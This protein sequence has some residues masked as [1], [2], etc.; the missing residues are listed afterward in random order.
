MALNINL[1]WYSMAAPHVA[2]VAALYL[3]AHPSA[4][5]SEVKQV[6]IDG[7]TEGKLDSGGL[8]KGTPNKI[9]YSLLNAMAPGSPGI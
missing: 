6:I 1:V 7:A 2:G 3:S 9:V 4:T 8:L 5:P